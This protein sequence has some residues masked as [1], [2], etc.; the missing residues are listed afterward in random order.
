MA[1][2]YFSTHITISTHNAL[3]VSPSG[4]HHGTCWFLEKPSPCLTCKSLEI[5]RDRSLCV[6]GLGTC[7]GRPGVWRAFG[8]GSLDE[9]RIRYQPCAVWLAPSR[10]HLAHWEAHAPLYGTQTARR[11]RGQPGGEREPQPG[12]CALATPGD[13]RRSGGD[14]VILLFPHQP[15]QIFVNPSCYTRCGRRTRD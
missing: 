11:P 10:P 15:S 13:A 8:R 14:S 3:V 6:R 7:V 4:S 2:P 1:F 9:L 5:V 12:A